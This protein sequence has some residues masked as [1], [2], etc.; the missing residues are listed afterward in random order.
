M[1]TGDKKIYTFV[2]FVYW[3]GLYVPLSSYDTPAP[4]YWKSTSKN[5]C[6]SFIY[7]FSFPTTSMSVVGG[8]GKVNNKHVY[9]STCDNDMRNIVHTIQWK[10]GTPLGYRRCP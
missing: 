2:T 7:K 5:K 9:D 3:S 8:V 1:Y 6:T 10:I 4:C